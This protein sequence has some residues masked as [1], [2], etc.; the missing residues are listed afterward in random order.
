MAIEAC[1]PAQMNRSWFAVFVLLMLSLVCQPAGATDEQL[2]PP[3]ES[4]WA[5]AA[6]TPG[7]TDYIY[8]DIFLANLS[9]SSMDAW[10]ATWRF[11]E[12]RRPGYSNWSYRSGFG[13]VVYS[14]KSIRC[15]GVGGDVKGVLSDTTSVQ[16]FY[17]C[18]SGAEFVSRD[19]GAGGLPFGFRCVT[20]A[21]EPPEPPPDEDLG[22][23][24]DGPGDGPG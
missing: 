2:I 12:F 17:Y 6:Y 10:N 4:K 7:Y 9:C 24:R 3:L 23:P 21:C 20:S 22:G 14:Y 16:M 11:L 19:S 5:F 8:E 18:P 13:K 1:A 15:I